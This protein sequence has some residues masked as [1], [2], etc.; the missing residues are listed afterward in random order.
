M[1]HERSRLNAVRPPDR[2][3]CSGRNLE[4]PVVWTANAG[5]QFGAQRGVAISD[6]VANPRAASDGD[7]CVARGSTPVGDGTLEGDRK[8][9]WLSN[10]TDPNSLPIESGTS[11]VGGEFDCSR[12]PRRS[13]L[14]GDYAGT[15]GRMAPTAEAISR[16]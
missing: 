1:V 9:L 5:G 14:C 7:A 2:R 10:Q 11:F 12:H 15:N 3:M 8:S 13:I 4:S 6:E 16:I